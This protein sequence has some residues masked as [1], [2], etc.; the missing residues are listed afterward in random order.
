[1][2]DR[3]RDSWE[4]GWEPDPEPAPRG[5]RIVSWLITLTLLGVVAAGGYLVWH[6]VHK[7]LTAEQCVAVGTNGDSVTVD[8]DQAAN[9][10]TIAAV[11]H[12]KNLPVHAVVVALATARQESHIRNLTYGDRDS[13]GLFQQRPSQGWGTADQISDPVYSTGRFYK[14]L[15]NVKDWQTIGVGVAAQSVQ[16]SA[17]PS[18]DSYAQWEPMATILADALTGQAGASITCSFGQASN[19]A[20]ETAGTDGFTPRAAAVSSSLAHAYGFNGAVAA[21]S[22]SA[23]P[24][25]LSVV[26]KAASGATPDDLTRAYAR[27]AVSSAQVLNIDQVAYADQVW[28]RDSGKWTTASGTPLS[29]Q[30][31]VSVAKGG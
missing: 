2:P 7:Q 21:P 19:L 24:D 8:N 6:T 22:V 25:G 16:H 26:I 4:P 9:A 29:G 15:V 10:A 30:V 20:V 27:W 5:R 31:K 11:A 18:G 12:A 28:T 1:M 23:S 13:I 14:A 17:D 3:D